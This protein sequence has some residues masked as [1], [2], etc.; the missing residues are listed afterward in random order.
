MNFWERFSAWISSLPRRRRL[1]VSESEAAFLVGARSAGDS[2]RDRC[3]YDREEVLA[4]AL[5]AWRQSPL[6][7]R[8]VELTS[9][10][11]VG[12]GI[13]VSCKHE[14]TAK[15]LMEVWSHR[16]NRL[17]VR[18]TEWCDELTRTGNLF[19]LV[20]TDPGG[21]SFFRAVPASD[22]DK[23]ESLANDIEQETRFIPRSS[24][25]QP[26]P[27]GYRAYDSTSDQ[28][29]ENGFY[30]VV[31][32]HYAINKPVGA[33]WGESDLAPNLRWFS[34]YA[35]WLE[36]RARLNRFR[37]A[38]LY[39]VKAKFTSEAERKTR[40]TLLA[41]N[42]PTP[43]SILVVDESEEWSVISPKLESADANTDGLAIKKMIAAGSGIP[44][45]FLAEPESS[46]KT[47]A[48]AAGGPTYRRFEQRQRYFLWLVGDLLQVAVNRRSLVDRHVSRK[49]DVDIRGAD[50]SARDN[51]ALGL[52]GRHVAAV[53]SDLRDRGLIDDE[54][55]LRLVYRF[56]GENVEVE[57]MLRKGKKAPEPV[58]KG[59]LEPE[60]KTPTQAGSHPA[61]R[62]IGD[63]DIEIDPET[64]EPKSEK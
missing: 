62:P 44:L 29:N 46:T 64:G 60:V 52:S 17:D 59:E 22:I 55:L 33:Q 6:A 10:Y 19:I 57:E 2:R 11:V 26:D 9:Q 42:P 20:S 1:A 4:Q 30:P 38:F 23:I 37:N 3:E 25:E 7:R 54:E 40:Q 43:G 24:I 5:E 45:H 31:M 21:M 34:R 14:S 15:F 41:A 61:K 47:T 49:A 48:E 12:E 27:T 16:L 13:M 51:M 28:L 18:V 50:I 32:L 35:S 63:P 58:L 8:I 36:D 53:V 39:V 56:L